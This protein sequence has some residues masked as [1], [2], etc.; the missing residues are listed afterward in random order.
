M[1]RKLKQMKE[2]LAKKYHLT[3]LGLFGSYARSEQT[4]FSDLDIVEELEISSMFDLIGIKQEIEEQLKLP[5]DIV[6]YRSNMNTYLKSHIEN[7]TMY[8]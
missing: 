4:E 6:R 8:V 3:K 1:L 2:E 5:V 7:D